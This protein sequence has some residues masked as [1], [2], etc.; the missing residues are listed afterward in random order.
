MRIYNCV[1]TEWLV[2]VEIIYAKNSNGGDLQSTKKLRETTQ[3]LAL[4]DKN[5]TFQELT[6]GKTRDSQI[7]YFECL[8]RIFA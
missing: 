2:L 3:N 8:E 4:V 1:H 5:R 7:D 6:Y